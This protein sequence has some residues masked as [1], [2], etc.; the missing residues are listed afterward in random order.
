MELITKV[1]SNYWPILLVFVAILVIGAV[2]IFLWNRRR[3]KGRTVTA[4]DATG[5][6]AQSTSS[7]FVH[8][9]I[10]H[11]GTEREIEVPRELILSTSRP[12]F[13]RMMG[14]KKVIFLECIPESIR[15]TLSPAQVEDKGNGGNGKKNLDF[16]EVLGQKKEESPVTPEAPKQR[17]KRKTKNA[18]HSIEG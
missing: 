12:L 6:L 16:L 9:V 10:F 17:R 15:L 2:G 5:G 4:K 13:P 14:N 11:N 18:K 3:S 1:V 8:G 7:D